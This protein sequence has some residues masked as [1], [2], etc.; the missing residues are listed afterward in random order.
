[1]T[2]AEAYESHAEKYAAIEGEEIDT[3]VEDLRTSL[4]RRKLTRREIQAHA[5]ILR[6]WL[7]TEIEAPLVILP[8]DMIKAARRHAAAHYVLATSTV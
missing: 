4:A 1:M 2:Y 7:Q 3:I 6:R 8:A 5:D